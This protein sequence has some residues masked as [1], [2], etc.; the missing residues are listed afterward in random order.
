[1]TGPS[2]LDRCL[3]SILASAPRPAAVVVVD[4]APSDDRARGCVAAH[5]GAGVPVTYVHEP[6]PG[7]GRAHNAALPEVTTPYVAFTDDDVVV[8]PAWVGAIAGGFEAAPDVACVTGLIAPAELRTAEQWWVECGTGFAKGFERQ[9]RSLDGEGESSLFPFDAGTF[10]SGANMAFTTEFLRDLGGFDPALGAGTRALGGD[11][12]AA[13]HQAVRLGHTLVY[14]PAALVFHRHHAD[15]SALRRQAHGYGAGLTA[16]LTH[17]VARRPAAAL[18]IMRRAVPGTARALLPGSELNARR[19]ATY[20][21]RL[22]WRER[23]G[24]LT[25]PARYLW[26]CRIDR[27]EDCSR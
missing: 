2:V 24:M 10:G 23:A 22:V 11:D 17:A 9:L 25:G 14:E 20:P 16:Y 26:Q 6:R 27:R 3:D 8:D 5:Q 12:L 7:L 21:S 18:E 15:L 19:P 13:L 4:S 1:M